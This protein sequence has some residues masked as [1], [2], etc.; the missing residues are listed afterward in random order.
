LVI[1][2]IVSF[3]TD[4]SYTSARCAATSPVVNP[5]AVNEMTR[6]SIP[7]RRRC[8]FATIRGMNDASRSRGTS[9]STGPASVTTV[10]AR[11]PFREFPPSRPTRSC[12]P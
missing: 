4:T 12:L 9:I 8:R 6:S 5:F 2:E 11:V 3:D 10:F 7:D 1:V